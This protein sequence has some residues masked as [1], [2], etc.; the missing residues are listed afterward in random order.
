[1]KIH[2]CADMEGTCGVYSWMQVNPPET[3]WGSGPVK[4]SEYDRCCARMTAE[5]S[6]AARGGFAAGASAV[7]VNDFHSGNRNILIDDLDDRC[8][9]VSG[10]AGPLNFL[11]GMTTDTV[12][13]FFTGFHAKAGTRS[14][15]LSHTWSTNLNDLRIAGEST[16][17]FGLIAYSAGALGV[18]VLLVTGDQ[19]ACDQTEAF[20][21]RPVAKAV[22]KEGIS[23]TGAISMHPR[24][25]QQLIEEK[26][27]EAMALI[28]KVEP[29]MLPRDARVELEFDH[30]TRADAAEQQ[31]GA[32]RVGNRTVAFVAADGIDLLQKF[33][34]TM[35]ASGV[36]LSP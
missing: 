28:G 17:E 31:A 29:M 36:T 19:T 23:Q 24:R 1:M 35:R 18:P 10:G 8:R 33:V 22:V 2:I 26:A 4:E 12:G 15:A 27:A 30:Q 3:P 14:S 7:L 34:R 20:L 25:A 5:V 6:A 13:L 21:K 11:Q 9:L 16:G 32:E